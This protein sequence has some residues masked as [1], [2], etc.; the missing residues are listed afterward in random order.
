MNSQ[1]A[2]DVLLQ[3]DGFLGS[4]VGFAGEV[5]DTVRALLRLLVEPDSGAIFRARV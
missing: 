5:P 2:Y 1:E 3:A 4:M